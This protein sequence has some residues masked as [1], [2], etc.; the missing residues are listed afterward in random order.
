[1]KRII[2]Y[3]A[4]CGL[5]LFLSCQSNKFSVMQDTA[6]ALHGADGRL[7]SGAGCVRHSPL[8]GAAAAVSAGQKLPP[9]LRD[10]QAQARPYRT[11]NIDRSQH[12][13]SCDSGHQFRWKIL[14]RTALRL[15]RGTAGIPMSGGSGT[16]GL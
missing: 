1:M 13:V 3:F 4:F 7:L 10:P 15:S 11:G 12:T 16:A 14:S 9:H 5:L 2:K 8:H 6:D